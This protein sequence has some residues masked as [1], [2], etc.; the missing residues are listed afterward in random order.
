MSIITLS[1]ALIQRLASTDRRIL[2]DRVVS[3]FCLRLNKRT[4][5]FFIATTAAGKQV[6]VTIGR[7]PLISTD[8]ARERATKLLLACRMGIV[9]A[10]PINAA[11]PTLRDVLPVYA[12]TKGLKASSLARYDSILRTHF[13]DWLDRE[14]KD[15]G[16]SMFSDHCHRFSRSQGASIVDVGRGLITSLIK[17]VNATHG[18][19]L[20]SPFVKLAAAGLMPSRAQPRK[21]VLQEDQLPLWYAA[22]QR[23]GEKQRD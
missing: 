5:T 7:W 2:R 6:R 11:L 13:A 20:D 18:L 22:V 14:I 8:E 1:D 9:P 19:T 4:R 17:F 12:E 23:L 15:L 21:R 3:G 10:K 16:L